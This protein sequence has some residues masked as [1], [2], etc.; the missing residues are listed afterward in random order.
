LKIGCPAITISSDGLA[1]IDAE[2]C[3]GCGVCTQ[4]C[5]NDAIAEAKR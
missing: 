5:P 2:S 3:G 1:V 4:V